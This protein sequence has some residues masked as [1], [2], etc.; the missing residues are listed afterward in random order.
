MLV[1][2]CSESSDSLSPSFFFSPPFSEDFI[3]LGV[4]PIWFSSICISYLQSERDSD[5]TF[6]FFFLNLPPTSPSS[7]PFPSPS[8]SHHLLTCLLSLTPPGLLLVWVGPFSDDPTSTTVLYL[9]L[10]SE[11]FSLGTFFSNVLPSSVVIL[12]RTFSLSSAIC[13]PSGS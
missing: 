13:W 12:T 10:K 1:S 11:I 6:F 8:S 4:R 5:L 9:F 3:S 2:L 7:Y